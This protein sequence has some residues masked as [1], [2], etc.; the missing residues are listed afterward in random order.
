[1]DPL[2]IGRQRQAMTLLIKESLEPL[3]AKRL[4]SKAAWWIL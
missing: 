3:L 1:M 2:E 4:R